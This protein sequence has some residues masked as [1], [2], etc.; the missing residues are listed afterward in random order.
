MVLLLLVGRTPAVGQ[1]YVFRRG[2]KE[3]WEWKGGE[4]LVDD[5]STPYILMAEAMSQ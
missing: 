2:K 4:A 1:A 5:D 3:R